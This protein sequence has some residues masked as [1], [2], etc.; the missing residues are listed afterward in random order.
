MSNNPDTWSDFETALRASVRYSGIGFMFGNGIFG[1]DLDHVVTDT[2][3]F[4]DTAREFLQTLQ[5]YAEYSPSGTGLHILCRGTIPPGRRRNDKK[6]VEIYQSGRFFTVTGNAIPG[7]DAK[8]YPLRECTQAVAVLHAKYLQAKDTEGDRQSRALYS[9]PCRPF[10]TAQN[11]EREPGPAPLAAEI[12][13]KALRAKNG[14]KFHTLWMGDWQEWYPSQSSADLALA[15]MLLYWTNGDT[16]K[17]DELFRQSGLMRPKWD[18]LRGQDTYGAMTLRLASQTCKPREAQIAIQRQAEPPAPA[19][20]PGSLSNPAENSSN[21]A[22]N[23]ESFFESAQIGRNPRY[24]RD[25]IGFSNLFFDRYQEAVCFVT[26]AKRWF[27]YDGIRWVPD[28]MGHTVSRLCK[29]FTKDL[30]DYAVSQ[31]DEPLIK[32]AGKLLL[33]NKRD[34]LIRDSESIRPRRISDFDKDP[35]LLNCK[36]GTY[37]L[38]TGSMRPHDSRDMLT[39]TIR[40]EYRQGASCARWERFINEI[41]MGGQD[42]A[43]YLQKAMGYALSGDTSRECFFILYGKET[44]NGKGTLCETILQLMGDYGQAAQPETIGVK[45]NIDGS[46]PSPDIASLKGA[47]YVSLAEPDRSLDINAALMKQLTGGDS[48]KG[49]FLHANPFTFKPEFKFF[50][51]T[52]HLP[53]IG[54]DTLFSSGRVKLILFERHFSQEEQ[55][56]GLK[57]YFQ[58]SDN[59]SGILNWLLQGWKLL[60]EEGLEEPPVI[61]KDIEEYR[62]GSDTIYQFTQECVVF[63]PRNKGLKTSALYSRYADWARQYGYHAMNNR[64]FVQELRRFYE[65]KKNGHYGNYI[66]G[67]ELRELRGDGITYA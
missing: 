55:D 26:E 46:A 40:A 7:R 63:C 29:D 20:Q 21:P 47:R 59:L 31:G 25:D 18:E 48:W 34:S 64:N 53:Y 28:E 35:Y 17:A 13:T 32:A 11:K 51:N 33:K 16:A 41:M 12:L 15:A 44:R 54:D 52:N 45:R 50:I 62:H 19:K 43:R 14:G 1:V 6:G 27:A 66:S 30:F 56:G 5:S 23:L 37:D 38:R 8:Y 3:T 67:V 60:Q 39:K 10:A 24:S 57:E 49:R 36:N 9:A 61:Q 22:G 42:K 65:V 4:S 58:R 2:G